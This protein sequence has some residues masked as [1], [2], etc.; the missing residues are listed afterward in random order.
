[1]TSGRTKPCPALLPSFTASTPSSAAGSASRGRLRLRPARWPHVPPRT[2]DQAGAPRARR[3]RAHVGRRRASH[4]VVRVGD[5]ARRAAHRLAAHRRPRHPR[6]G[7]A[8]EA[9]ER[10]A[11]R[12]RPRQAWWQAGAAGWW[13][14]DNHAYSDPSGALFELKGP[15]AAS[16]T[17]TSPVG[18]GADRPRR[19]TSRPTPAA[20]HS[21]SFSPPDRPA[22]R[23]PSRM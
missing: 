11:G 2:A 22:T 21:R 8:G 15:S 3:L 7:H 16:R 6:R 9:R 4:L 5:S 19:C 12:R 1:M 17:T 13:M 18:P 20:D 23:Q 14:A 10:G